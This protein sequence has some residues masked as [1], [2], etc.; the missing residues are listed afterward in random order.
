[1]QKPLPIAFDNINADMAAA[2]CKKKIYARAKDHIKIMV[3]TNSGD[4]DVTFSLR[5]VTDPLHIRIDKAIETATENLTSKK[6]EGLDRCNE[7]Y[8]T[9]SEMLEV[10]QTLLGESSQEFNDVRDQVAESMRQCLVAY[11]N[12]TKNWSETLPMMEQALNIAI[13]KKTVENVKRDLDAYRENDRLNL[14]W[15]CQKNVRSENSDY[16][17]DMYRIITFNVDNI[18]TDPDTREAI[19]S[20]SPEQRKQVADT[21]VYGGT[22]RITRSLSI[23]V[24]RCPDCKKIHE[25]TYKNLG[26]NWIIGLIL[27]SLLFPPLLF[28]LPVVGVI[29]GQVFYSKR[30]KKLGTH[31]KEYANEFVVVKE[32][33]KKKWLIGKPAYYILTR[34]NQ[35]NKLKISSLNHKKRR[36]IHENR[37]YRIKRK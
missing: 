17:L 22:P 12:H 1:M 28:V 4:D 34:Y 35:E 37:K 11:G 9:V 25:S 27:L 19:A 29:L 7:L 3:A 36:A 14:C 5:R 31:K 23:N 6:D 33:I 24:P 10:L 21:I 2:Y 8:Y 18:L 15:Y 20:L 13:G 26:C 16:K 32:L 30:L